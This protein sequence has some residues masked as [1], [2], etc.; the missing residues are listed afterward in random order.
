MNDDIRFTGNLQK[1]LFGR[2]TLCAIIT[3]HQFH[4][5][6]AH[7]TILS[8]FFKIFTFGHLLDTSSHFCRFISS[9]ETNLTIRSK[10]TE[11]KI[12]DFCSGSYATIFGD[13]IRRRVKQV[14]LAFYK[15]VPT[16]LF[17]DSDFPGWTF[18]IPQEEGTC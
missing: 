9:L 1:V 5:I 15:T 8:D 11:M 10:T 16:S 18:T 4:G 6:F 12:E 3:V 13:E 2:S 17:A 7:Q 14:P